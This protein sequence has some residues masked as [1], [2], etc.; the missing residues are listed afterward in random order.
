MSI[1]RNP[2][3]I[4]SYD[5]N[6]VAFSAYAKHTQEIEDI[7]NAICAAVV[8]GVSELSFDLNDDFSDED[9]KYIKQEVERRMTDG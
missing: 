5:G 2:F 3:N 7:I 1:N 4:W 6:D 9:I 8:A